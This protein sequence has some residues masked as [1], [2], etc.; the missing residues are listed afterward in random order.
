MSDPFFVLAEQAPP[1]LFVWRN[2]A[3]PPREV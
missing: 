1:A 3:N 2:P